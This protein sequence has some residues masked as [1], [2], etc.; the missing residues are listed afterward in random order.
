MLVLEHYDDLDWARDKTKTVADY[1]D[2]PLTWKNQ[3]VTLDLSASN[4]QRL[5]ELLDPA[6]KAGK[7]TTPTGRAGKGMA[8]QR[9]RGRRTSAYYEGLVAWVD[10]NHITKRDTSGRAAYAGTRPDRNDYPDWLIV[11]YDEHLAAT[12]QAA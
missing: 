5:S 8:K 7:H 3:A 6:V 4:Y 2:V 11:M 1:H 9:I 12:G 10:A